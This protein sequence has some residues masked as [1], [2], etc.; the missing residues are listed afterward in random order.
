MRAWRLLIAAALLTASP[1]V[2][3]QPGAT[4]SVQWQNGAA[5]VIKTDGG[6]SAAGTTRAANTTKIK[7]RRANTC[8]TQT[9]GEWGELCL[10]D[11]GVLWICAGSSG[12]N[13]ANWSALAIGNASGS[14]TDITSTAITSGDIETGDLP[15]GATL[16]T[17]WDTAAEINTA[18]TDDDFVRLTTSQSISGDKTFSG[19]QLWTADAAQV[20]T[21]LASASSPLTLPTSIVKTFTT[22][23]TSG[24]WTLSADPV[25]ATS[26]ATAYQPVF[27]CNAESSATECVVLRDK[28]IDANSGLALRSSER[29]L[30]GG[31]CMLLGYNGTDWTELN[32]GA[33]RLLEGATDKGL[34]T[35]VT[36][37]AAQFDIATGTITLSSLVTLLGSTIS[38][39]EM[40]GSD[41]VFNDQANDFSTFTQTVNA[42]LYKNDAGTTRL[43]MGVAANNA[44][45]YSG[46][47]SNADDLATKGDVDTRYSFPLMGWWANTANNAS[48]TKYFTSATTSTT[49]S[50]TYMVIPTACTVRALRV[51]FTRFGAYPSSATMTV[52]LRKNGSSSGA[53]S[54]NITTIGGSF[55]EVCSDTSTSPLSFA[56][57][58]VYAFSVACSGTCTDTGTTIYARPVAECVNP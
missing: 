27:L 51:F 26:G 54:C 43:D 20:S 2:G 5:D 52:T 38:S 17:E 29:T 7:Q 30:C 57:D 41:L 15:S 36:F 22:S 32:P 42:F 44:V 47:Y 58:D 12:C 18:T 40:S 16:D 13:A 45:R 48:S 11:A 34:N 46:D 56:Q 35:Q 8:S 23:G 1:A 53:F 49:E 3:I 31:S 19:K 37:D 33:V 9:D 6:D 25:L 24:T 14:A 55:R 4:G 50:I 10:D 21:P 28:S 39:D